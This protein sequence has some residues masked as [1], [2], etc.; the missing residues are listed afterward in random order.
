MIAEEKPSIAILIY[1]PP[2]KRSNADKE[3]GR[4]IESATTINPPG[5]ERRWQGDGS[6]LGPIGDD[7]RASISHNELLPPSSEESHFQ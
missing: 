2:E 6:S 1:L 3:V 4:E 7:R 5:G